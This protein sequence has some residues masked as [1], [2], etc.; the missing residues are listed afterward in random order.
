LGRA[1][2][3]TPDIRLAYGGLAEVDTPEFWFAMQVAVICGFCTA[4][5]AGLKEKM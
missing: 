4:I 5:N 1:R 3:S 2:E